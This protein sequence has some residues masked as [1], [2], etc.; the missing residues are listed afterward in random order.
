MLVIFGPHP[1]FFSFFDHTNQRVLSNKSPKALFV[2]NNKDLLVLN[3]KAQFGS[4][5]KS[6]FDCEM[7]HYTS[8]ACVFRT[9][10]IVHII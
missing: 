7:M 2:L 10:N 5:Y 3:N 4:Y 1:S 9:V 8:Y 6:Y